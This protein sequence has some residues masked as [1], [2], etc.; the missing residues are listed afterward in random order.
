VLGQQKAW[1]KWLHLGEYF[2]NTTHHM[3]IGIPPFRAL[4]NY[5]PLSFVDIFFGD[6]RDPMF[7]DWIQQSHDILKE[8]KEHMQREHNQQK[9]QSNKHR[10]ECT[11]EV[12]DLFYLRLQPYNMNPLRGVAQKISNL[13]FL[14]HIGSTER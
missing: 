13:D 5:D 12:V 6:N 4:Y 1:V 10:V 8:L 3:S 2:Y 14:V 11:F 9:V 7:Q